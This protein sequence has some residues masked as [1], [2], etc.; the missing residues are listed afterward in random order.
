MIQ[1]PIFYSNKRFQLAAIAL[2]LVGFLF[3]GLGLLL[4]LKSHENW[5]ALLVLASLSLAFIVPALVLYKKDNDLSL[6]ISTD[7]LKIHRKSGAVSIPYSSIV[8]YRYGSFRTEYAGMV[9]VSAA[10]VHGTQ[11]A[12]KGKLGD[13]VLDTVSVLILEAGDGKKY[14]IGSQYR[15]NRLC[16][17]L[18]L[19]KINPLL[20]PSLQST[21]ESYQEIFFGKVKLSK[22]NLSLG[23]KA[24]NFSSETRFFLRRGY[25]CIGTGKKHFGTIRIFDI[26]NFFCFVQLLT[27]N[28][29]RNFDKPYTKP[30]LVQI[31]AFCVVGLVTIGTGVLA[32]YFGKPVHDVS[33]LYF[34][35]SVGLLCIVGSGI[36]WLKEMRRPLEF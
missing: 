6:T 14:R 31:V 11:I 3:F 17:S 20:F 18:I 29:G 30:A 9:G 22:N 21:F 16:C 24:F 34:M 2:S 7:Q 23:E 12:A 25:F 36:G 26:P 1:D 33:A 5:P 28:S 27:Q 32:Y 19:K 8:S 10:L 35:G 15:S 13:S 4:Y